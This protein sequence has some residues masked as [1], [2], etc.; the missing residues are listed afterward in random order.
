M[1]LSPADVLKRGLKYLQ[2]DFSKKSEAKKNKDFHKH[3]GSSTLV[4]ANM[5]YDLTVSDIAEARISE[6][7]QCDKGF[8]MFLMAHF[9]L[10][11]YPKNADLLASR[12]RIGERCSRGEPLWLWIRRIAALKGL[13]IKWNPRFNDPDAEIFI[14]TIDGTDFRTWEKKH[15]TLNKDRQMC[16]HKFNHAAVKYEIAISIQT[17]EVAYINGPKIGSKHDLTMFREGELL[18][19]IPDGKLGVTDR[20]YQTSVLA[21]RPK[22]SLPSAYDPPHLNNFKSRARLRHETFNGRIKFFNVLSDTF[23]HGFDKHKFVFEAV[24]VIVQ[25][26]MENGS[27]LY[28]V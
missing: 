2:I 23:R 28:D 27:P 18:Q 4:L 9:F 8:K 15:P 16:S 1:L 11:T 12:F 3:Y 5:W 20:G 19:L 6:P 14:V 10:W 13:K 22:L 17:S 7:E 25:Y 21:E 24:V 26:Q